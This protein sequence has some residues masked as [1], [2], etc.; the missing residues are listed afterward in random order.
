MSLADKIRSAPARIQ[1][2]LERA[3]NSTLDPINREIHTIL[4]VQGSD[5]DRSKPGEPPRKQTGRLQRTTYA[6]WTVNPI[7]ISIVSEAPYAQI[8]D[9]QLNRPIV[10]PIRE[11]VH[12]LVRNLIR[13]GLR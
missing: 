3:A 13:D 11:R 2:K 4:G 6:K 12:W 1:A 9:K 7:R 10:Q 8:L 5:S